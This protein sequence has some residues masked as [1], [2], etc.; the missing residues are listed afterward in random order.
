MWGR[1][2]SNAVIR[3]AGMCALASH[4]GGEKGK[5]NPGGENIPAAIN[6]IN[7]DHIAPC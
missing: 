7:A 4:P 5:N 2:H 1:A 3:R 6:N